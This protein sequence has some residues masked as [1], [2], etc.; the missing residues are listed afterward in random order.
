M[1]NTLIISTTQKPYR[2]KQAKKGRKSKQKKQSKNKTL[3]VTVPQQQLNQKK[4]GDAFDAGGFFF[5]F[6]FNVYKGGKKLRHL[7]FGL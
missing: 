1:Q 7:L 4:S 3:T 2:W 5:F 6:F